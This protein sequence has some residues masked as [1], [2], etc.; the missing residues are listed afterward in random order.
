MSLPAGQQRALNRIEQTLAHDDPGLG[1]LFATFTKLVG[2]EAMPV[3]ERVTARRWWLR[4]QRRVSPT[5]ATL[6]GLAMAVAALFTLSLTMASPPVCP[7][8]VI[9]VAAHTQPVPT[10]REQAC[11]T[12]RLRRS[13]P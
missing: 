13:G 6:V 7:G 3:T 4:W 12:A 10:G 5:V 9:A 8:T 11:V 2:R 1:P